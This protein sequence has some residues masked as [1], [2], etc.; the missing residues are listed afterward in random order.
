LTFTVPTPPERVEVAVHTI[1]GEYPI[2]LTDHNLL[3]IDNHHPSQL[4]DKQDDLCFHD[5]V[6]SGM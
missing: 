1:H 4:R 5:D 3:H 2:S 6:E